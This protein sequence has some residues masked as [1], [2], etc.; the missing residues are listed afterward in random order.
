MVKRG[1]ED[2][3]VEEEEDDDW[4]TFANNSGTCVGRRLVGKPTEAASKRMSGSDKEG[5]R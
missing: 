5:V 2:E 4:G 1:T 3:E